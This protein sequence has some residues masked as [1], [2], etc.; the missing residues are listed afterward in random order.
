[1]NLVHL[2]LQRRRPGSGGD[3][4][5]LDPR[6]GSAAAINSVVFLFLRRM[7]LPLVVLISVYAVSIAGLVAIPGVDPEG[8][9]WRF[10]LF[11]AF[12]FISYTGSTIGFGEVPYAFTPAQRLW[13]TVCIYLTVIGWLYAVGTILNLLQDPAFRRA[14]AESRFAGEVRGLAEPFWIIC[15]YGEAGSLLVRALCRRGVQTVVLDADAER[16][17]RLDLEDVGFDV[18]CLAADARASRILRLAGLVHPRCLGVVAIAADDAI[19]VKVAITAKLLNPRLR[20]I[21][22]AEHASTAAN[23][24]SFETDRIIDAYETFG[25]HLAMALVEPSLHMLYEYLI[26]QPGQPLPPR[27]VP[28]RGQ[29][30]VCGHGRFGSAAYRHLAGAGLPVRV[31]ESDPDD[32]PEDAV[33]GDATTANTLCSAGALSAAGLVAGT[34][35]D[36]DNLSIAYT[37]RLLNPDLFVI[38]RANHREEEPLFAAAGLDLVISPSRLIVWRVLG[39]LIAPQTNR[40]L[41]LAQRRGEA[42]AAP[43]LARLDACSEGLT[44]DTW[45]TTIDAAQAPALHALLAA[46]RR[47]DFAALLRDPQDRSRPLPVLLLL[48]VGADGHEQLLPPPEA[49]PVAGD[50]LLFAG[51]SGSAATLA[52]IFGSPKTLEYVLDGVEHPDGTVWRWLARRRAAHPRP[53]QGNTP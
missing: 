6:E 4:A 41:A 49:Q 1:M 40:F 9:P 16:L 12:Y 26:R 25:E 15:G 2:L 11:H 7:R 18:P 24:A 36:A 32:A 44:P 23:L 45:E 42:W 17:A 3:A 21:A 46:G 27:L 5:P 37:A 35:D 20:V 50:R 39:E 14:L 30:I 43:L 31:I 8:R 51:R 13:V 53:V 33:L 47:P 48:R 34:D 19:D 29:W 28:P 52:W 10:D 38:A 22:R